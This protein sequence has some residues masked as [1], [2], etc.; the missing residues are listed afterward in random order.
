PRDRLARGCGRPRPRRPEIS[1]D[2][3]RESAYGLRLLAR[4]R[5]NRNARSRRCLVSHKPVEN[6]EFLPQQGFDIKS[7]A[8]PIGFFIALFFARSSMLAFTVRLSSCRRFAGDRMA[9]GLARAGRPGHL[10]Q[11]ADRRR[12]LRLSNSSSTD[13]KHSWAV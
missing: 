10:S 5:R 2:E 11:V 1:G 3:A 12:P 6:R 9:F 8:R 13:V 4:G 7:I